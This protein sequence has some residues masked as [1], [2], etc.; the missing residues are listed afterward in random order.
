M[1]KIWIKIFNN[2]K[3][4]EKSEQKGCLFMSPEKRLDAVQFC[5]AQY[6]KINKELKNEGGK[7]LRGAV[8]VIKQK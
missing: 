7:G 2:F 4:A 1:K 6:Y 5:R 3:E 8:R